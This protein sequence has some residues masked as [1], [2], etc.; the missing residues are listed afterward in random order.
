MR[1]SF[2]ISFQNDNSEC[3]GSLKIMCAYINTST[4]NRF[5]RKHSLH[6]A[7]T[8]FHEPVR[9]HTTIPAATRALIVSGTPACSLSS[10]PVAPRSVKCDSSIAYESRIRH[11]RF[12]VASSASSCFCRHV[13]YSCDVNVLLAITSV[14][15][16]WRAYDCRY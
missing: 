14:R 2:R 12:S 8:I 10:I 6:C 5:A 7:C 15:N 13:S 11:S 1:M 9:T 3:N 4:F 16:P